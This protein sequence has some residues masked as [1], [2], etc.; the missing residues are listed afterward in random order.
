M[1]ITLP[2]PELDA[3][4]NAFEIITGNFA[5]TLPV[6]A[7]DAVGSIPILIADVNIKFNSLIKT[8]GIITSTVK[9]KDIIN[10]IVV[11]TLKFDSK[12]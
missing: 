7:L 2:L 8:T 4:G 1:A 10:S 5:I 9:E 12:G 3:V 11:N 6:P